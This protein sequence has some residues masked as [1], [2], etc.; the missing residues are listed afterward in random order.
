MNVQDQHTTQKKWL[1]SS[2]VMQLMKVNNST[3]DTWC[4]LKVVMYCSMQGKVY[5]DAADI[6]WLQQIGIP[7]YK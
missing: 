1:D 6:E 7:V 2:A 4:K 5:Y 3:L